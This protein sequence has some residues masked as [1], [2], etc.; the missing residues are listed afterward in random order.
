MLMATLICM[1]HYGRFFDAWVVELNVLYWSLFS[2]RDRLGCSAY[3][4]FCF[5]F[6]KCF[7]CWALPCWT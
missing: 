2:R 1:S 5:A 6:L 4:S 7:N 3:S